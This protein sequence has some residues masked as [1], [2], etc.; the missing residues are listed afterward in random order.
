MSVATFI[1]RVLGFLRDMVIAFYLGAT[2]LSDAFYVSFR[3]PNLLR[4]IF[5]EGSTSA[6]FI[7][8]ISEYNLKEG[9]EGAKRLVRVIFTFLL[10]VVGGMTILGI[11]LTPG[12]VTVIAPNFLHFPAKFALT[13]QLTRVMFPFLLF[14]SLA[15][16][17]MG[18]LNTRGVFFIPALAPALLN[19][20]MVAAVIVFVPMMTP[21]MA[22]AVGV[23]LGGFVQYAFQ[24]PSFFKAG[25]DFRIEPRFGHPGLKR[26]LVLVLPATVAMGVAQIN[27]LV[28]TALASYLPEGSI[29]YLF[30]ATRLIHFPVG[31]FGV[32]MGLAVLPALSEHAIKKDFLNLRQDFSFALRV[33]FFITLPAMAGLIAFKE[34]IVSA[35][36]MRGKFDWAATIATANTLLFYSLGIWAMVGVR[37]LNATFYSMQDTR[38][39]VKCAIVSLLSN[40]ILSVS[41]IGPLQYLG[42]ALANALASTVNFSILFYA[43]RRRLARLEGRRIAKSFL[44][45]VAG[46]S[47]LMLMGILISRLDLWHLPGMAALKASWLAAGIVLSFGA[48]LFVCYLLKSDELGYLVKFLKERAN[49]NR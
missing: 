27:I 40:I 24:I 9:T 20:V 44:K 47:A 45:S 12:I 18:A 30:Y 25:F 49:K 48:Y 19:I 15:S 37:V 1:S 29:T 34:P 5:A 3:I 17:V 2:G 11:I 31:I 46:C 10:T 13:V 26:A 35:L 6:A 14:I 7:P 23:T 38:L 33:L 21:M 36:F 32:A 22:A 42:L 28:S 39:P 4:E 43:L 8:V 16:L 41:L